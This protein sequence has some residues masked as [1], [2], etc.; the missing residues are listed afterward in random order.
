MCC[1]SLSSSLFVHVVGR[2]AVSVSL[3]TD[4]RTFISRQD[5]AKYPFALS[6]FAFRRIPMA[7]IRGIVLKHQCIAIWIWICSRDRAPNWGTTLM[8]LWI[9]NQTLKITLNTTILYCL[10]TF[11]VKYQATKYTES[12]IIAH[13]ALQRDFIT[14]WQFATSISLTH[15][16]QK[17]QLTS[18]CCKLDILDITQ[19]QN[20]PKQQL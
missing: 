5:F 15:C 3:I 2:F 9:F 10:N 11:S 7:L 17:R 14:K 20:D 12:W 8:K 1:A 13:Q 19:L 18:C 4:F 6:R 16:L